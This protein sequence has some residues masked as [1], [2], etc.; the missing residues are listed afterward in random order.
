MNQVQK[1]MLWAAASTLMASCSQ[2][3]D[4]E[5][6]YLQ[7]GTP[8]VVTAEV[9]GLQT[10]VVN[11]TQ[12]EA[13]DV[14]GL[15]T[16]IDANIPYVTA[17][18]TGVFKPQGED[19]LYIKGSSTVNVAGYYPHSSAVSGNTLAFDVVGDD[20]PDYMHASTTA[21]K[22]N[23]EVKLNFSHVMSRL[24]F[25]FNTEI[26]SYAI[27]GLVTKGEFDIFT[28]EVTLA[29]TEVNDI[30][31]TKTRTV[32]AF[33]PPQNISAAKL[34]F[35]KDGVSYVANLAEKDLIQSNQYTYTV[36]LKE[37]GVEVSVPA[38]N[39]ISGFTDNNMS[40]LEFTEQEPEMAVGDWYLNDGTTV[41]HVKTLTDEQKA[42]VIGVVVYKGNPSTTALATLFNETEGAWKTKCDPTKVTVDY[43]AVNYP[44]C[45]NGIVMAIGGRDEKVAFLEE[46]TE[47]TIT[48]WWNGQEDLKAMTMAPCA[49]D[50]KDATGAKVAGS[51]RYYCLGLQN[52]HILEKYVEAGNSVTAITNL[53]AY[54]T[55]NAVPEGTS[56]WYIPSPMEITQFLFGNETDGVKTVINNSLTAVGASKIIND[57]YWSSSE[58]AFKVVDGANVNQWYFGR[59]K[60]ATDKTTNTN[61]YS[62]D[63]N[64]GNAN[65]T[66]RNIYFLAF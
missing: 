42:K 34:C 38:G 1:I 51:N 26:D 41:S 28:G 9:G 61:I 56:G 44:T 63:M 32:T 22:E 6:D 14:I 13:N 25:N 15:S 2:E 52:T 50:I 4:R 18:E 60:K 23:P 3:M 7:G 43:M 64:K 12:W 49:D 45:T 59:I 53:N 11:F 46:N 40:N 27:K 31:G 8:A 54:R 33:I 47:A 30:T 48:E 57:Q 29:S 10:R 20:N 17:D 39:T 19:I 35:V 21:T 62:I 55:A 24:V 36:N 65:A 37:T 5:D 66:Y 16:E 58:S